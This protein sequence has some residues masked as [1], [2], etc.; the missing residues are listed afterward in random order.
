MLLDNPGRLMKA[1]LPETGH[2]ILGS[3]LKSLSVVCV[4]MIG[5]DPICGKCE[6]ACDCDRVTA[7]DRDCG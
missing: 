5:W 1:H 4:C 2:A 3:I 7:C 6:T